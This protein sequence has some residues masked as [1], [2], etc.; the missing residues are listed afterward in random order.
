ML[1]YSIYLVYI[2]KNFLTQTHTHIH[3]YVVVV[4]VYIHISLSNYG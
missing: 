2:I 1:V 4:V 3:K